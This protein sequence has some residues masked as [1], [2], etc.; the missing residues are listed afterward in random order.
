MGGITDLTQ[1]MNAVNR[2]VN[3][4]L[5]RDNVKLW[6]EAGMVAELGKTLTRQGV[7]LMDIVHALMYC[8]HGIESKTNI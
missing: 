8:I 1:S 5:L 4:L 3:M 7:Q 2:M 6:L